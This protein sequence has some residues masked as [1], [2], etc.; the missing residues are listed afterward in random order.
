[1]CLTYM[2]YSQQE[3]QQYESQGSET[4]GQVCLEDSEKAKRHIALSAW[5][6]GSRVVPEVR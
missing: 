4:A 3:A 5:S 2:A 1:M 6:T